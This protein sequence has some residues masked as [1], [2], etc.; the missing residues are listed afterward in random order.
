MGRSFDERIAEAVD[1]ISTARS[2]PKY[3]S[4][5]DRLEIATENLVSLIR[6]KSQIPVW[7]CWIILTPLLAISY[8][9]LPFHHYEYPEDDPWRAWA[10][11][12]IILA[13]LL[14]GM[15]LQKRYEKRLLGRYAQWVK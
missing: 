5:A 13:P 12:G 9:M 8:E 7:W 2:N 15:L 1:Q 11:T 3:R 10:Y 4:S 6:A 14:P